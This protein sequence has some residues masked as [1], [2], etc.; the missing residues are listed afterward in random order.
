MV[1]DGVEFRRMNKPYL[2]A[3]RN[4]YHVIMPM[5]AKLQIDNG[6]PIIAMQVEN[7]YGSYGC[8]KE[9]LKVLRQM[10]IDDGITVPLFTAD[11][12]ADICIQGGM[13][14]G[15]PMSLTFGSRG[16]NAFELGKKYRP[17]DPSF[18]ME[19]WDGWFDHWG[20]QTHIDRNAEEVADEVDDML[21]AGGSINLYMF[22]G[23][24]NFAFTN[25]AN[26]FPGEEYTPDITSYDYD[27]PLSECG[28]ITEK[29]LKIQEVVKKYRPDAP[30]A[31]PEA[32][33]KLAYGKVYFTECAE[34][35]DCIDGLAEPVRKINPE[36]MEKLG[37]AFGF[38]HYRARVNGPLCCSIGLWD[39][40]D[41]ALVYLDGKQIFT[42]YR[43][44]KQN[45]SPEIEIP[46][47][48]AWLDVLVENMGRINYGTLIG[49]DFKGICDGVTLGNQ[50]I[51]NWD[52]YS[53]PMDNKQLAKIPFQPYQQIVQ[54]KPAFYRANLEIQDVADTFI[55]FP[56]VKGVI[57]VNGHNLGRYW[58][59]GPSSTLYVPAPYL[60][61]GSN[62]IIV[63][64]TERLSRHYVNF[65][66]KP[67]LK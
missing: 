24:T 66:D 63:F 64:E 5:L 18:C 40:K 3:I 14:E 31:I 46:A 6:G 61:K 8:D 25:G 19:F 51:F 22:H 2:D 7:E 34:L 45:R 62:E 53:L 50:Y 30:F 9:Y 59:I 12:A 29:Y 57:W 33:R 15:T 54:N 48:G 52:M 21:H 4:Y 41:R 27:A 55:K 26:G 36:C 11:G 32:P 47:E 38:T 44:D 35:F 49:K 17:D 39:V 67:C 1:K 13:L 10:S 58:E 43:N 65:I 23:G 60:K 56:G 42:Y 37:Q 28:D 20:G 16:A